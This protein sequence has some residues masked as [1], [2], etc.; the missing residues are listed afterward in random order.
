MVHLSTDKK[1]KNKI[2]VIGVLYMLGRPNAFLS[3]VR[4]YFGL[5]L[6]IIPYFKIINHMHNW[7][8]EA[9]LNLWSVN[10]THNSHGW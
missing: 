1:V 10:D 4:F 9:N 3:K 5:I 2:A 6:L 8:N 7:F